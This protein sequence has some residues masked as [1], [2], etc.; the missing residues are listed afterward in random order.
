[1]QKFMYFGVM[2]LWLLGFWF[3]LMFSWLS[4][5]KGNFQGMHALL[6]GLFNLASWVGSFALAMRWTYR[7]FGL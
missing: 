2:W 3:L 7:K 1:M 5:A 6:F 4:L